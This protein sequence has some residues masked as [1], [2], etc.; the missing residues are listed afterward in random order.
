MLSDVHLTNSDTHTQ[1]C[2]GPNPMRTDI[3]KFIIDRNQEQSNSFCDAGARGSRQLYRNR[4]S[5]EIAA[6][7]CMDGRLNLSVMTETPVGIL[8]PY[9][10][11][12]G[13]FDLGWPYLKDLIKDWVNYSISRGRN[14]LVLATYHFSKGDPHRGCKGF[15]YNTDAAIT[16]GFELVGQFKRV[17]GMTFVYPILVGIETDEDSLIFHNTEGQEF[18][19]ADNVTME[20]LELAQ[21]FS[22]LY[23]SMDS[24]VRMDLL[25]LV[26][27]NQRH[28]VKIR[29]MN[30]QP[31]ELDHREQII[32]VGRGFDWLHLPNK[33]LIIGPYSTLWNEA[34]V[35]AGRIVLDNFKNGRL[36]PDE[37]VLLL[38]SSL[39]RDVKGSYGWNLEIEKARFITRLAQKILAEKLPELTN[40]HQICTITGVVDGHTR[41]MHRYD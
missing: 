1:L 25:E 33:A 40:D 20:P 21:A 38:V 3:T 39:A 28:V 9:R 12:G 35:T 6:L 2:C 8:H 14:C 22:T 19:V 41:L 13:E 11:L 27:G 23:P 32:A 37:G 5:T 10:N 16:S 31:L 36:A 15:N 29:A 34:V 18:S 30:R 7:K 4:H 26:K 17:F 24:T